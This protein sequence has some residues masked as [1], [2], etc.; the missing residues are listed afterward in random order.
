MGS[1]IYVDNDMFTLKVKNSRVA[2][3]NHATYWQKGTSFSTVS[4]SQITGSYSFFSN[5]VK[6]TAY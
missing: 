5:F 3:M 2:P 1:G 4:V 6:K